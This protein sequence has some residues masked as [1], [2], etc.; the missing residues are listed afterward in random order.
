MHVKT[1]EHNLSQSYGSLEEGE[2]SCDSV[3]E[4]KRAYMYYKSDLRDGMS[5]LQ[6]PLG[7]EDWEFVGLAVNQVNQVY[8]GRYLT[9]IAW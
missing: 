3:T 7:S 1:L 5:L 9:T 2:I 4:V 6:F 8:Q